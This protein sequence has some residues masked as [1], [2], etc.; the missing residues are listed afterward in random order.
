MQ[1]CQSVRVS[2]CQSVRVQRTSQRHGHCL[3]HSSTLELLHPELKKSDDLRIA[4]F[5]ARLPTP[6]SRLPRTY[7]KLQSSRAPV[8]QLDR[9]SGYEPDGR[10]F[11]SLRARHFSRPKAAK[12]QLT[13]ANA[14]QARARPRNSSRRILP[15]GAPPQEFGC[16]ASASHRP[17][18]AHLPRAKAADTPA[19]SRDPLIL[20]L[21][22]LPQSVRGRESTE[23][24]SASPGAPAAAR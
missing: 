11:E 12:P 6:H 10:E 17:P 4:D 21:Q 1:Q 3:L 13:R 23:P 16:N 9:A 5:S 18:V 2:E 8:A 24:S 15:G 14:R 20:G 22:S 7:A 19:H